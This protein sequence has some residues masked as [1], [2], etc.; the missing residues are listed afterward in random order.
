VNGSITGNR[1][2]AL[3]NVTTDDEAIWNLRI[4]QRIN[5]P[6]KNQVGRHWAVFN[7][8]KL[9]KLQLFKLEFETGHVLVK[10]HMMALDIAS[11]RNA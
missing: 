5:E 3:C 8:R 4:L 9:S 1:E 7:L 11:R 2:K 10:E 6:P